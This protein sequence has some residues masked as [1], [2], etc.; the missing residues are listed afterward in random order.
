MGC[1]IHQ[2]RLLADMSEHI[3]LVTPASAG[4]CLWGLLKTLAACGAD[5]L[6]SKK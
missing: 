4:D 3:L 5:N 2:P 6:L 1:L